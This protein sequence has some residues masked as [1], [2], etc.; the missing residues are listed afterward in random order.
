MFLALWGGTFGRAPTFTPSLS[1]CDGAGL[2]TFSVLA[3]STTLQIAWG[4]HLASPSDWPGKGAASSREPYAVSVAVTSV[5]ETSIAVKP[6][7]V[8]P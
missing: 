7:A 5:G 3:R 4:G 1:G 6:G 8:S 2:L